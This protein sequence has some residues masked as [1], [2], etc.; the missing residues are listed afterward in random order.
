MAK[1]VMPI[2]KPNFNNLKSVHELGRIITYE[3]TKQGLTIEELAGFSNMSSK[4]INKLENGATGS[5]IETFLKTSKALGLNIRIES[6]H[7]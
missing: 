5:R 7:D 3:R 6:A 2:D 4:T 1:R